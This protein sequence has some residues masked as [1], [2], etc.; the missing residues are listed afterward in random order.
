MI[1]ARTTP[2]LLLFSQSPFNVVEPES[3]TAKPRSSSV[4]TVDMDSSSVLRSYV[5]LLERYKVR[6]PPYT[7]LLPTS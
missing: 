4:D 6:S 2:N 5:D 3:S 7:D 1:F